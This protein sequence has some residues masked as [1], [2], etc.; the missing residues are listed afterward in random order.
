ML[1]YK[2]REEKLFKYEH[3]WDIMRNNPKWCTR[4]LT[5]SGTSK[6]QKSIDDSS[7]D[8]SLPSPQTT[9]ESSLPRG[10]DDISL[11]NEMTEDG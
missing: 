5:K 2:G 8:N 10:D 3:C 9:M 6:K 1:V 11:D 7:T 4:Q